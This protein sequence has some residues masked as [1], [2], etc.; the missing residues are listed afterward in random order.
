MPKPALIHTDDTLELVWKW[1]L[2]LVGL[3]AF[4]YVLLVKDGNVPSAVYVGIFGFIGLPSVVGWQKTLNDRLVAS[5]QSD[6]G[7]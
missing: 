6:R 2:R 3:V 7:G 5:S 4:G 1:L